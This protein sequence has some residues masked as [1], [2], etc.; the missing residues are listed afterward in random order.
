MIQVGAKR[1]VCEKNN[2]IGECGEFV[3]GIKKLREDVQM[4]EDSITSV[5]AST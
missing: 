1:R 3:I 2:A 5:N 4:K